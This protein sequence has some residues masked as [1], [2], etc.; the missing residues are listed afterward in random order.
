M[1]TQL[2]DSPRA[3][4]DS[5]RHTEASHFGDVTGLVDIGSGAR[6]E[7]LDQKR[8]RLHEGGVG[9]AMRSPAGLAHV[10][11][12]PERNASSTRRVCKGGA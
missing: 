1:P 12:R 8:K 9:P 2:P 3:G 5:L 6:R 10:L 11:S 4:F 7:T